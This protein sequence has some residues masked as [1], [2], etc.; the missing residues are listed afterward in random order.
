MLAVLSERYVRA[1]RELGL[2]AVPLIF[3]PQPG[4][5]SSDNFRTLAGVVEVIMCDI[6]DAAVLALTH[7]VVE[8]YW[9]SRASTFDEVGVTRL[10]RLGFDMRQAWRC[11]EEPGVKAALD[12]PDSGIPKVHSCL[13]HC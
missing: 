9:A 12:T 5:L 10:Q 11:L 13:L 6:G 1:A 8:W 4:R 2:R 3:T 7:A